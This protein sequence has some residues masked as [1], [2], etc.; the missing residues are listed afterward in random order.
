MILYSS[1]ENSDLVKLSVSVN[2]LDLE[3]IADENQISQVLLNLVQ[4]ALQANENNIEGKIRIVAGFNTEQHPEIRVID[5]GPGVSDE[6]IEQIFIP[7]FTTRKNGSGVGL[8]I[9]RQIM[10]LHGGSLQVRSTQNKETVFRMIFPS[11]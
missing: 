10:R 4:N 7:F 1:L 3:L 2:P 5:N 11:T 6:I 8:S 9:S